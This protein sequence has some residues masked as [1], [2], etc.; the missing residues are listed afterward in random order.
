MLTLGT[1][2]TRIPYRRDISRLSASL[3]A[4]CAAHDLIQGSGIGFSLQYYYNGLTN[5]KPQPWLPFVRVTLLLANI[6]A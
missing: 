6:I 3:H 2:K 1:A 5:I 4:P